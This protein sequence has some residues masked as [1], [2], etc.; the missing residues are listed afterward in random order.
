MSDPFLQRRILA[1][2]V[3]FVGVSWL[4]GCEPLRKKFTRQKKAPVGQEILPVL[5]PIDY[6]EKIEAPADI[7]RQ[8]YGLWKVWFQETMTSLQDKSTDKR[9]R[10]NLTQLE[11]QVERLEVL[12]SGEPVKILKGCRDRLV[13]VKAKM[14]QPEGLRN[15]DLIKAELIAIDKDF[16][17]HFRPE[18]AT[19]LLSK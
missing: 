1:V 8:N 4:V 6:P 18:V 9:I 3:F 10:F 13:K 14:E 11:T 7:L 15:M 2:L 5:E 16:R 12:F 19:A 17:A